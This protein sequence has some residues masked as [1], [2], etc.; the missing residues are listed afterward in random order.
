M[1]LFDDVSPPFERLLVAN[2]GEIAV[3]VI[4]A[5]RE[6]GILSVAVYTD[7][8]RAALH[9]R[10][11]DEAVGIGPP[12]AYLDVEALLDAAR[13]AKAEAVHPGYGFLSESGEFARAVEEAGLI[14]VGP[15]AQ[16][17]ALL[18]DKLAARRCMS[19]AGVPVVPGSEPL[20]DEGQLAQAAD[21]LELPVMIK[22][23]AGG[24]GKGMRLVRHRDELDGAF[25]AARSEAGS[26]FGDDRVYLEKAVT[27]PRHIEVQVLADHG[28][29][30]LHVGERECSVQ[31]R[32]Q[33]LVEE[34]PSPAVDEAMRS[35]LGRRAVEAARAVGY[36]NA[37]TVEFLAD[38]SD[39]FYFLEM[40]TRIQV[41]HP[42]T[43]MITGIDLVKAQLLIAAGRGMEI[44]QTQVSFQGHAVEC[45]IYAEDPE[46]D[47]M[48]SPGTITALRVPEGPWV[49]HDAG[50]GQGSTVPLD[51]DSLLAKL[52][53]WGVDRNEAL[54]RMRRAL[55]EYRVG[56]V[57]TNVPLHLR[58]LS[59]KR[60]V[61][62]VYDTGLLANGLEELPADPELDRAAV[63]AASLSIARERRARA[64]QR[65]GTSPWVLAGRKA[66]MR[67]HR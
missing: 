10:L 26:F 43:E 36:T 29:H 55:T 61:S 63:L 40:N 35:E 62:G 59:D 49:R 50:V 15:P 25:R 31:R 58:V 54:E 38:A 42:V 13:R 28:G 60:F 17:I 34:A 32:H 4:R 23:A 21:A 46:R 47:F 7:V 1:R 66:A 11:A 12:R 56:G 53:V 18:G 9:V 52:V 5:C 6:L 24:G 22:A 65:P 2:R 14:W 30:T 37:G 8:D 51:Y 39:E 67:K 27:R 45:R 20:S 57:V 33:K 41:E 19:E 48:P 64:P 16:A 3:R 44:D